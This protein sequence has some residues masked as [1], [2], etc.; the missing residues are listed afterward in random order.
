[1]KKQRTI[2]LKVENADTTKD[3]RFRIQRVREGP[4]CALLKTPFPECQN[5]KV[6][7]VV[8]HFEFGGG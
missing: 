2:N 8:I 6:E 3:C 4:I 1:M 7:K 5:C